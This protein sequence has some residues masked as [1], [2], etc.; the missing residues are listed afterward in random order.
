MTEH[1]YFL[2]FQLA[3]VSEQRNQSYH[4]HLGRK[5]MLSIIPLFLY[6][7]LASDSEQRNQSYH[8]HCGRR[9]ILSSIPLFLYQI[10]AS[11]SEQRNQS[12]H[13]HCGS[14]VILSIILLF[15]PASVSEQIN[16]VQNN[17]LYMFYIPPIKLRKI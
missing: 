11:A 8:L 14:K 3:S 12:Y 16:N 2:I 13:P 17:N 5:A 6:Q 7:M 1:S 10:L 4:P 15:Q 9:A